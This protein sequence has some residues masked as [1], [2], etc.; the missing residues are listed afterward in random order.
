MS[1]LERGFVSE[2]NFLLGQY[3]GKLSLEL[4]Y[5]MIVDAKKFHLFPLILWVS[6][7]FRLFSV[8]CV[9]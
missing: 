3:W 4:K 7:Y 5:M 2:T 6:A 1:L 8:F 9:C